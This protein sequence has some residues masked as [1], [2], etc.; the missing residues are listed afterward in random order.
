MSA[1]VDWALDQLASVVTNQPAADPLRRVDRD[2]SEVYE[3]GQT[4]DMATPIRER[5]GELQEA[6][7]VGVR[8]ADRS[9]EPIGTEYDHRL[10]TVLGVRIEGLDASAY[11][12]V[13]PDGTDGVAF[14]GAGGLIP[15]IREAILSARTFPDAGRPAVGYTDA[16]LANETNRSANY[17]DYYRYDFDIVL[18]G[19]ENLP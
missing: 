8:L 11:G 6:N 17:A 10:E 14:D 19:Y 3:T 2:D 16:R 18:R 1:E 7:Y 15:Q 13:D 4:V 9:P 12:H 5:S